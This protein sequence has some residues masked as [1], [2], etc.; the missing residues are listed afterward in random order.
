MAHHGLSPLPNAIQLFE[1]SCDNVLYLE[2]LD[3]AR[4]SCTL[5]LTRGI[6]RQYH[7]PKHICNKYVTGLLC[8]PYTNAAYN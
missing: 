2:S 5:W 6:F 8:I 3:S 4:P 7:G 1:S